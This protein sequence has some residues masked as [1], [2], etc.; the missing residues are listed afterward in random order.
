MQRL[1]DADQQQLASLQK[2]QQDLQSEL[3]AAQDAFSRVDAR[4]TT[5]RAQLDRTQDTQERTRLTDSIARHE[6]AW[7]RDRDHFNLVLERRR[8][9]QAELETLDD[10]IALENEIVTQLT[11]AASTSSVLAEPA[12]AEVSAPA[13][14]SAASSTAVPALPGIP[15]PAAP[16]P[17]AGSSQI[18][19]AEAPDPDLVEARHIDRIKQA[20]LK[21]ALQYNARLQRGVDVFERDLTTSRRLLETAQKELAASDDHVRSLDTRIAEKRAASAP[22]DDL[23]KLTERRT[24]AQRHVDETRED[25]DR[26]TARVAN[27][28]AALA[29]LRDSLAQAARRLERV[30]KEAKE[31]QSHVHF[32]QGP[33]APHQISQWF[34]NRSPRVLTTL[35]FAFLALI[36]MRIVGRHLVGRLITQGRRGTAQDRAGR[37]ETLQ[38]V[39]VST[40]TVAIIVLGLL[41]AL[42]Q[43]GIDVTVLLG[44][45][46]VVGAAVAFG[47]QNLI[48]DFFSGF[49]I[50]IENQYSVGNVVRIG[51][52]TGTVEDITLRMTALRDLEGV[53]HFI[54][55]SQ[56]A[57]VSN[58][59]YGWSRIVLDI[60]VSAKENADRVMDELM[61]LARA[62]KADQSLGAQI[63]D[64]P[65][66]L[67]VD[68]L[69]NNAMSIKFLIKTRPLFRWA[70]K[71][72]MLRRIKKRFD[73]LGIK[74]G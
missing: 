60:P 58:L 20:A 26:Q 6:Q 17:S 54:P 66:M 10:K 3:A 45:A 33:F 13:T 35:F 56:V 68:S 50:L 27:T 53:L 21:S 18:P 9:V 62:L 55:H 8:A 48:R 22:E 65:E 74:F 44:G 63:V 37:G 71:R 38:R 47:S 4:L 11:S 69:D 24:E 2:E 28:E 52:T 34:V 39:F 70:V 5:E 7:T 23:A 1:L 25:V 41:A 72:E 42:N 73:E 49:M 15:L 12:P 36:V 57:S 46:A 43:A 32:L 51:D 59:T 40:A 67:G 30:E 19:E 64:D 29:G 16:I 61:Q 31:S 14:P